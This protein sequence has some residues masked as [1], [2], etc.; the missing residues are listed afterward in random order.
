MAKTQSK[1]KKDLRQFFRVFFSRGW[2]TKLCFGLIVVFVFC[3]LLAPIL[4]Q[5]TPYEQDLLSMLQGPSA[6][7]LL[8]TDMLGRDTLPA[9]CTA[10]AFR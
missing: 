5:Y 10:P 1:F 3:A 7:H 2:V 9:C 4:T 8:G 6:K